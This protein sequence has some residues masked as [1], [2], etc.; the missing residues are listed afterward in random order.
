MSNS[1]SLP[2]VSSKEYAKLYGLSDGALD[3]SRLRAALKAITL[4]ASAG[5]KLSPKTLAWRREEL[6]AIGAS[7]AMIHE[8]E[9]FDPAAATLEQLAAPNP[10]ASVHGA[11]A[12]NLIYHAI[13]LAQIDG[14]NDAERASVAAA[15]KKF[16]V[17]A[18]V[19]KALEEHAAAWHAAEQQGDLDQ[20]KLQEL[21]KKRQ[22][23]LST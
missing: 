15:A 19:V 10:L 1:R 3:E 16:G 14:Y 4:I 11:A 23:V 20:A 2:K 12:R 17:A 5:K 22:A 9:A 7:E 13:R 18:P 6:A 8:I 21:R